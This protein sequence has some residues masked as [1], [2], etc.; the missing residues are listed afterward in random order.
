MYNVQFKGQYIP[1]YCTKNH[2]RMR[3][4]RFVPSM[5]GRNGNV[6]ESFYFVVLLLYCNIGHF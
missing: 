2:I 5:Q 4:V 6:I 3:L 1:V